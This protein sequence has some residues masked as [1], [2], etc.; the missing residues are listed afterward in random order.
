MV[1]LRKPPVDDVDNDEAQTECCDA[2]IDKH[3][4][5]TERE[6]ASCESQGSSNSRYDGQA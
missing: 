4:P 3:W 1:Y 2:D 5:L 6:R